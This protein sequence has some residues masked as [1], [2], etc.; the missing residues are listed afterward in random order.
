M[1][2]KLLKLSPFKKKEDSI[3]TLIET[4][5]KIKF[6]CGN[7]Q[8][9]SSISIH[10]FLNILSNCSSNQFSRFTIQHSN[11]IP[12]LK[13]LFEHIIHYSKFPPKNISNN[14]LLEIN[15]NLIQKLNYLITQLEKYLIPHLG[16]E[17]D[18]NVITLIPDQQSIKKNI[19]NSDLF[20]EIDKSASLI[21]MQIDPK[22]STSKNYDPRTLK[23][24]NPKDITPNSISP[25]NNWN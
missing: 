11:I 7:R 6:H 19:L 13:L 9:T 24:V 5:E 17:F 18:F 2:K 25:K 22:N 15:E 14:A 3:K 20:D 23:Q 21:L 8:S 1:I 10:Y 12:E 16:K 4:L